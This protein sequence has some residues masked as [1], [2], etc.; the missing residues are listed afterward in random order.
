MGPATHAD[1]QYART[2]FVIMPYGVRDVGARRVNFDR[3]Y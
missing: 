1:E 3:V 2:C